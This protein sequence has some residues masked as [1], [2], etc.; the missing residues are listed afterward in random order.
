MTR[1]WPGSKAP[2]FRGTDQDGQ[3][4]KLV[5]HAGSVCVID[6]GSATID[7]AAEEIARRRALIQSFAGRPLRWIGGLLD[8]GN[9]RSFRES[10]GAAGVNWRCVLLGS[11]E[12]EIPRLWSIGVVPALFVV[13]SQGVISARNL[14]WTEQQALL[15]TLVSEA[16]RTHKPR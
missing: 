6:F 12:N 13:D 14:P 8:S 15:E 16:E 1:V 2:D 4:V 10:L 3:P 7:F 9:P 5:D 11:R